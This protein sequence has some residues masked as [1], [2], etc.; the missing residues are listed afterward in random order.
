MLHDKLKE[1]HI[2]LGSGSPR[3][4]YLL[5]ELGFDFEVRVN[6]E[7]EEAYP[8]GLASKEI[9]VYLAELKA[10]AIMK[11]IPSKTLVITADTIVWLDDKVINKPRD[12]TDAIRML[13]KLSGNMHE[14]LTGVCIRSSIEMRSF[15]AS[16]LVWFTNL[17]DD[18]ILYYVDHHRP[19]DKAGA[20]G[21]QDW[22][23]YIG[24]EKIEGS[25]F[26]VM[27]LPIQKLYH[28]LKCMLGE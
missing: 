25:Y 11:H 3:R 18:E 4:Q 12:R 10:R 13:R 6:S 1:Y 9:P 14:V 27:G 21:I 24:I 19:F 23:G 5:N 26:N 8:D 22:I 7:L 17:T 2:I 28:E 20:Y 15:H 16:S